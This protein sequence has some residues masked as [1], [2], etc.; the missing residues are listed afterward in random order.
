MDKFT[1]NIHWRR[2]DDFMYA[3]PSRNIGPPKIFYGDVEPNDIKQG[4]LGNCWFMSALASLAERPKL[5]ENLI[6]T[7]EKNKEGVYR[8]KICKNGNWIEVTIDDFFPCNPFGGPI[9]S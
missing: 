1:K 6:I 2:V 3:I 8:V 4:E 7:K 9:F 5:V